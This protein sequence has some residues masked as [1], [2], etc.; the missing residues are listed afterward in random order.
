MAR[1]PV[2]MRLDD[3]A[4]FR[5]GSAFPD[6]YQGRAEGPYPFI[7]VADLDTPGNA[8]LI[9]GASH[10][11]D[12]ADFEALRPPLHPVGATVFAK[13][14]AAL[15]LNRR[16]R[17]T[18]P[19]AIDNNMMSAEALPGTDPDFLFVLLQTID[20]GRICQGGGLPSVNQELLGELEVVR[21]DLPRQRRVV[22]AVECWDALIDAA[23]RL[24]ASR[25]R[26]FDWIRQTVLGG[27]VRLAG[28]TAPWR[29]V[30]LADIL[31]EHGDR[32]T[33]QE[34]VYSVS[35]HVG[36][37]DQIEH[38]GRSFAAADTA[39]YNRVHPG[40][41]VY[42]KSPTGDFPLGVIKQ[43]KIDRRVIV[44][45]LYG[46]FTPETRELGVIIDAWF[47]APGSALRYLTPL[48]QKGAK[49]TIAVTN[50][51]FLQGDIRV[52]IDPDEVG[53]L[54]RVI[55]E[56]DREIKLGQRHIDLL[57]RQKQGLLRRLLGGDDDARV[58][59][60]ADPVE[61]RSPALEAA[62]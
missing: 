31:T 51:Q 29:R 56:A 58:P 28:F 47:S 16:R 13:V 43:S 62:Q 5:G 27:D 55:E 41:I 45:P 20:L 44:S 21:P 49:N 39:N 42:T 37:I 32:S 9:T 10:W 35:V 12:E 38:L 33:G 57:Q 54:A 61:S 36:L 4:V 14:G 6:R 7:K 60:P 3:I 23:E 53:A 26:R 18:R 25:R 8:G 17:L 52:P 30:P 34:P 15:R 22:E 19:T 50:T 11:L 24:L 40:D 46:V 59:A 2:K 48:V 1:N